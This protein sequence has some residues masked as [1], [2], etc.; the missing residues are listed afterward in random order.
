MGNLTMS[1]NL[2]GKSQEPA[3]RL[4]FAGCPCVCTASATGHSFSCTLDCSWCI[5]QNEIW[6][7]F[8]FACYEKEYKNLTP[9]CLSKAASR[10]LPERGNLCQSNYKSRMS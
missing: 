7:P 5:V 2:T 9:L 1:N 8:F 6:Y 10:H 3:S 4:P